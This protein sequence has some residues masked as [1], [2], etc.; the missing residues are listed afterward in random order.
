MPDISSIINELTRREY[1]SCEMQR[2][3]HGRGHTYPGLDFIVVDWYPPALFV[4]LFRQV[5]PDWL[6]TLV[7][8]LWLKRSSKVSAIVVQKR[9]GADTVCQLVKGEFEQ[10]HVISELGCK[11]NVQLLQSQNSGIFADMINGRAWV[12]ANSKG[13]NVLN[14]FAYTCGF[15]LAALQG[16]ARAVVNV[17]MNKSVMAT[18]RKNHQLNDLDV[19][20]VKFFTHNIF[21]S[22]GKIKRYGEYDLI[23]IDP[24]SFQKG[25]FVLTKD[26]QKLIKRLPTLAA[27]QADVLLCLN[28]P[29]VDSGFILDLVAEHCP[30]LQF[31]KRLENHPRFPE[32]DIK[33][34]LKVLQM[35]F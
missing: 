13:K 23:I 35:K 30:T 21:H 14:L 27:Q 32:I 34:S 10:P 22:W 15:S 25:S 11:F 16:G 12:K 29:E 17:D 28:S 2:I 33:K 1:D 7:E 9:Q 18:G 19:S 26:Y 8:Q 20:Q 3:F 4:C 24:P 5:E 6:E 31:I